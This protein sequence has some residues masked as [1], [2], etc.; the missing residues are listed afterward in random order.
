MVDLGDTTFVKPKFVQIAI[1]KPDTSPKKKDKPS[2][3]L[4]KLHDPNRYHYGNNK[5]HNFEESVSLLSRS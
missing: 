1:N 2:F 4:P 5:K 3:R